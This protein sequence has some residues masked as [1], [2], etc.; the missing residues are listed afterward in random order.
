MLEKQKI[1]SIQK[2]KNKSVQL[3]KIINQQQQHLPFHLSL[4]ID[5]NV[6]ALV[7]VKGNSC[8]ITMDG[9]GHS[10]R[11]FDINTHT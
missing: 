6:L 2:A 4:T 11:V 10:S 1:I 9:R 8:M 5:M 7:S 3:N